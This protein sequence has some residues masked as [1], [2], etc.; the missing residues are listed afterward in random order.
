[1]DVGNGPVAVDLGVDL[2]VDNGVS[3]VTDIDLGLEEAET[4]NSGPGNSNGNSGSGN[5]GSGNSGSGNDNSGQGNVVDN[6]LENLTR[7]SGKQ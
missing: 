2:G 4:D 7:R 5:S 6:L 1:M 3:V